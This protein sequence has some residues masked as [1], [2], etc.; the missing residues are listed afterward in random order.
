MCL[1]I[2]FYIFINNNYLVNITNINF[3][4]NISI[5][6]VKY[7][8]NTIIHNETFYYDSINIE[9]DFYDVYKPVCLFDFFGVINNINFILKHYENLYKNINIVMSNIFTQSIDFLFSELFNIF[10]TKNEIDKFIYR[11]EKCFIYNIKNYC[12]NLS[13]DK[14]KNNFV[15]IL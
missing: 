3:I 4:S 15:I 9:N 6:F 14:I 10:K 12:Y 7:D 2:Y 11:L 13:I 1:P 5:E 8:N